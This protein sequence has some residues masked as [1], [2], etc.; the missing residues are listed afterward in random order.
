MKVILVSSMALITFANVCAAS[1]EHPLPA[2]WKPDLSLVEDVVKR[3]YENGGQQG[4][5]L[6]TGRTYEIR[7]VELAL[8]YLQLYA[9]LPAKEQRTL[10]T[11]QAKW[12]KYRDDEVDKVTPKD[13]AR[14][15]IAPMEENDRATKISEE[16]IKE[17]KARF[18]KLR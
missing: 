18:E 3:H 10:K 13:S 9:V 1:P 11:E 17:L 15:T 7:D 2:E 12:L 4:F 16:R 6:Q 14:G 5:N 8:I